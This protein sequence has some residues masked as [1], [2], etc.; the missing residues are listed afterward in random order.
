M[1]Y[2]CIV[3]EVL[4]MGWLFLFQW[5]CHLHIFY[6]SKTVSNAIAQTQ[7]PLLHVNGALDLINTNGAGVK[8]TT[9]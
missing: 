9:K 3:K 6:R 1:Y 5:L 7:I 2:A 4:D 8:L